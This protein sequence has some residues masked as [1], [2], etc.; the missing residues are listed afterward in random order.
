MQSLESTVVSDNVLVNTAL[1]TLYGVFT[2][3]AIVAPKVVSIIGPRNAMV[4]GAIPYVLLVFA[5]MAPSYYTFIPAFAGVGFGAAILWTG[6]GIHL[7]RCT[8]KEAAQTGE[9]TEVVSSRFNGVFWT[10]FQFNAAVG[11]I[12]SSIIFQ[13]VANFSKAVNYLFLGLGIFGCLG[14]A[15]LLTVQSVPSGSAS[16]PADDSESALTANDH[17]STSDKSSD[18]GAGGAGGEAS[19]PDISL[20]E[21]LKLVGTSRAMQ[22]L[23]PVIFYNGASLGFHLANFPLL[24]QDVADAN[25]DVTTPRLLGKSL[26]GYV[27]ATFY[28]VNSAASYAGG[29][30]ATRYGALRKRGAGPMSSLRGGISRPT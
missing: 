26:V 28:L 16:G 6:Q 4:L 19:K 12:A 8:I 21:T 2:L 10:A 24:Y 27:A 11:L 20:I 23:I 13:S 14:V 7:S 29:L 30:F 15:V 5:N 9:S 18:D 17:A 25:G 22:L 1:F 3:M